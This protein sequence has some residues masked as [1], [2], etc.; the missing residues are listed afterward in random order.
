[1]NE[2]L[3]WIAAAVGV[4]GLSIGAIIYFARNDRVSPPPKPVAAAPAPELSVL[5]EEP[6][7]K[8]PLPEPPAQ[9]APPP[10][11]DQSDAPLQSALV[12][13]ISKES[14]DQFVK[15]KDLVRHIVVTV[16]NLSTE[17]VAE[18]LRPVSPIPGKFVVSGSEEAPTLDPANYDRYKSLVMLFRSTETSR[19]IATYAR[20]YPLFQ[21]A[22]ENLG[23]PPEYFND[24]LIEVIDHLLA[25]PELQ[26]PIALARPN[27]QFEYADPNL[28]ARS[29][30]QKVLLRM[31]PENAL[32]IKEKLREVR[33][34]LIA[35]QPP[36]IDR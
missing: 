28:E 21:Q 6:A 27:V 32:A 35:Q 13:L 36:A 25:T 26:E 20:Y 22:Y 18:R 4:V 33:A 17:K 15:P 30:G 8:H 12:D 29:A 14:V 10:P 3:K 5:P 2:N 24:R 9:E 23:H 1:M 7:I 31:G 34:A 19:L 16:D 11:L